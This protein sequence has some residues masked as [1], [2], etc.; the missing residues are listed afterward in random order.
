LLPFLRHRFCRL[1]GAV[2]DILDLLLH[3]RSDPICTVLHRRS[4][5][6]A[7]VRQLLFRLPGLG[8]PLLPLH[9]HPVACSSSPIRR[10]EK[11]EDA[12]QDHACSHAAHSYS[13]CRWFH[14]T[15]RLL[16][17][18]SLL[19][20]FLPFPEEGGPAGQLSPG[21]G[22][23][24]NRLTRKGFVAS[25]IT[26]PDLRICRKHLRRFRRFGL[27]GDQI[28]FRLPMNLLPVPVRNLHQV[29][30]TRCIPLGVPSFPRPPLFS[31]HRII[32]DPSPRMNRYRNK[33]MPVRRKRCPSLSHMCLA[34]P[35]IT[36][37]QQDRSPCSSSMLDVSTL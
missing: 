32:V 4:Q 16:I 8:L 24:F 1:I 21:P 11:R 2:P 23:P 27:F 15:D 9:G 25:I 36:P 31:R 12:S 28:C 5:R 18:G 10:K 29:D 30:G 19:V 3:R 14:G 34:T 13:S 20:D 7:P 37:G 35:A 17:N 26:Y 6:F 33:C 22:K